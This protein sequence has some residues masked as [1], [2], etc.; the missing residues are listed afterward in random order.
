[1]PKFVPGRGPLSAEIVVVGE[2]PGRQEE[3]QG[4]PFV[5]PSGK[6]QDAWIRGAGLDPVSIRYE[7][8]YPYLPPGGHIEAVPWEE[9]QQWQEDLRVRMDDLLDVRVVVPTGNVALSTFIQCHPSQAKITQRRG[10]IYL[11]SQASGRQVKVVPIIH[12]AAVLREE[13]ERSQEDGQKTKKNYEARCRRD[14]EK[15]AR[16]VHSIE[17]VPPWRDLRIQP[18]GEQWAGMVQML[19]AGEALAFDIET[20]P[21][22]GKI[23][24][25]SFAADPYWAV[26]VPW[27]KGYKDGIRALL[28]S[29]LPKITQN[30]HYDCLPGDAEVLTPYG[31]CRLNRLPIGK[32]RGSLRIAQWT[33]EGTVEWVEPLAVIRKPFEGNLVTAETRALS[34]A[35]T[36]THRIPVTHTSGYRRQALVVEDAASVR[37]QDVAVPISGM[38]QGGVDISWMRLLVA[39]QADASLTEERA[40]FN[41]KKERKIERLHALCASAGTSLR[42]IQ[43]KPDGERS[44]VLDGIYARLA[45][46]LLGKDRLWGSWLLQLSQETREMFLDELP[47]WDGT[48]ESRYFTKHKA[49]AEWVATV[50]HVTGRAAT[51]GSRGDV[52]AVNLRRRVDHRITGDKWGERHFNGTHV[53][54]VSVPSTFFLVRYKGRIHVTGN[55]YWLAQEGFHVNNWLWDTMAM[56]CLLWPNEPHSLAY[57]ASILTRE[58]WYKGTDE[59]AGEK[60]WAGSWR[61]DAMNQQ[62]VLDRW[63]ALLDYNAR[64]AA[65][66]WECWAG[67]LQRLEAKGWMQVYWDQYQALFQPILDVMLHGMVVNGKELASAYRTS[68]TMAQGA[69]ARAQSAAQVPLFTF[70]TQVQEA[71]WKVATWEWEASDPDV[72]KRLKRAKGDEAKYVAQVEAKGISNQILA[73]VLYDQMKLPTQRNRRTHAVTTDEAALLKLRARYKDGGK[74]PEGMALIEHVLQYR[75]QKKQ[76]EFLEPKRV[77]ADGRFRASYSFRPTTGRLSS[78]SNPR[79]SGGNAQNIDRSLRAPFKPDAGCL[80]LEVDLS[81]AEARVVYCLTGNKKLIEI[82]HTRPSQFDVHKYLATLFFPVTLEQVTKHERT[83]TKNIGHG[84]HYDLHLNKLSEMMLKQGYDFSPKQCGVM[85]GKYWDFTEGAIQAWQQRTRMDVLRDR[86]LTNAWGRTIEWPW[87][88]F[89]DDLYRKAYAWRPQSD[90]ARHLNHAWIGF[91]AQKG[92]KHYRSRVNLQLHDALIISVYPDEVYEVMRDVVWFCEQVH[93]YY[94]VTLIVP[95]EIKLGTAWSLGDVGEWKEMPSKEEVEACIQSQYCA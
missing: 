30:G 94:G 84:S 8:V 75:E 39:I 13:G 86:A 51:V 48:G 53:Y 33:Q 76:S 56:S 57:L 70:A 40:T 82:A 14:W 52:Y 87:D 10:S 23:L 64:D 55:C 80:L 34:L 1:M 91:E 2:A 4:L 18:T 24:C 66:T 47:F 25:I 43:R 29:D 32:R 44:F 42:E 5:G 77:D 85:Q 65:V 71:C 89:G 68:L 83:P 72:A 58:P 88:H 49:N 28:A 15:V 95:A 27:S 37:G 21:E 6:L 62:G 19:L 20:N 73:S 9:L 45:Y 78:S 12:P 81:Q 11:W 79:G 16:E 17:P 38:L 50:A 7:N 3:A 41:L 22:Q 46:G 60:R 92:E 26:S 90:I 67:L 36:P 54:C 31:W 59:D 74:Y 69:L 63:H 93:N 61:D 35:C